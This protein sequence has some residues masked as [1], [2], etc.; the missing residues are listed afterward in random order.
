[1]AISTLLNNTVKTRS[2][3]YTPTE[4]LSAG[5]YG[6]YQIPVPDEV[7]GKAIVSTSLGLVHPGVSG[8]MLLQV[9]MNLVI[10]CMYRIIL[11]EQ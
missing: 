2:W 7:K 1:M 8:G 11:Q 10:I 5:E 3:I 4:N 9:H 6:F